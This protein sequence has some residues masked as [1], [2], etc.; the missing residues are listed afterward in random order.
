MRLLLVGAFP[1]PHFQGSQV[2]F[3]EQAIALRAAGADVSLLTYGRAGE[4]TQA[5]RR[6]RTERRVT[7]PPGAEHDPRPGVFEPTEVGRSSAEH[8]RG[9]D[10]FE[11]LA[12]SGVAA[13][14]SLRS[15][16]NWAKPLADLNLAMTL[17]NA[18]ALSKNQNDAYDAILTHNAEATLVTLSSLPGRRPSIVYCAH[19]VLAREL[20]AYLKGP[21]LKGFSFGIVDGHEQGSARRPFAS[22]MTQALD[23]F[24]GAL[25]RGLARRADAWI[26]LTQSCARVMEC[27][28]DRPGSIVPPP[29]PDPDHSRERLRAG[30][31][32]RAHGLEAGRFF[33]Y[34]G[35]LDA[36]Q[37]LDLLAGAAR[38][39][40]RRSVSPPVLVIA[41]HRGG[42]PEG[43]AAAWAASIPG[44]AFREVDSS[45]EMQALITAARATLVM[46]RATGGFP[47]KLVNSLALSTPPIAF[48]AAEWGL[49]HEVDSLIA[50]PD[51][52]I[53]SLTEAIE[54]LDQDDVLA[55]RLAAGARA[56]FLERHL[57]E[58]AAAETLSLIEGLRTTGRG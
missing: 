15:G 26:A 9:L 32:A 8:W 58:K 1:Y 38:E 22:G 45:R 10:G 21:E 55:K 18:V 53:E 40:A 7:R 54:R 42:D 29:I 27:A 31:T 5:N 3:Q 44:V 33:L 36:Y 12:A 28:S 24:G 30:E 57:P 11:H 19:T 37:E 52:P 41:T 50:S 56:L 48:H 46:R 43:P 4:A 17:R 14:R 35:N 6:G 20:S 16:P 51:R 23:R 39:L 25:D 34:T 49:S 2:Y 47:I 13:R